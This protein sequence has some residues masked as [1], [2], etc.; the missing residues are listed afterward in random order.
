VP[1]SFELGDRFVE[2]L[3]LLAELKLRLRM[4]QAPARLVAVAKAALLLQAVDN[5]RRAPAA[6]SA[7]CRLMTVAQLFIVKLWLSMERMVVPPLELSGY[8]IG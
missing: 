7:R 4:R 6:P 5:L 3:L 2:L 8:Y 1:S